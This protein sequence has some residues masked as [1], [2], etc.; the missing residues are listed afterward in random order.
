MRTVKVQIQ[1]DTAQAVTQLQGVT[2]ALLDLDAVARRAAAN[3]MA[4]LNGMNPATLLPSTVGQDAHQA[5]EAH[6]QAD[7]VKAATHKVKKTADA[8]KIVAKTDKK[9]EAQFKKFADDIGKVFGDAFEGLISGGLK[10]ALKSFQDSLKSMFVGILKQMVSN[11]ATQIKNALSKKLISAFTGGGSGGGGANKISLGNVLTPKPGDSGGGSSVALPDTGPGPHPGA[12]GHSVIDIAATQAADQIAH[13]VTGHAATPVQTTTNGTQTGAPGGNTTIHEGGNMVTGAVGGPGKFQTQIASMLPGLGLSLGGMLGMGQAGPSLLGSAGGLL[14]GG[15]G[16]AF[17]APGLLTSA[18][19]G[20]LAA[21]GTA[22]TGLGGALAGLLTNPFTIAVAGALIV[23]AIIWGINS[24]RKKEEK[25]RNQ[26]M[27]DAFSQLDD[28]LKQVNSDQLDGASA[29]TQ[30]TGIR[31][32]YVD[33]MSQLK[34]KKTRNIALKDVSRIDDKIAQIRA[35]GDQQTARKAMD[36]K[37]VPTFADGG[38]V[39]APYGYKVLGGDGAFMQ[40]FNGRVPGVYDRRDDFLARLTGNEVVLTPD[41]WMPIA[42]YLKQKRVPGFADGGMVDGSSFN[43]SCQASSNQ[44]IVIE[45]LTIHLNNQ[46]GADSAAKIL[47]VAVKTP[48]GQKAVVKSVRTHIGESGLGDGLVR[49]IN[50]VNE[51]GF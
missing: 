14:A 16:M 47:G 28:L 7:A 30:A 2:R 23:G 50:S 27:L 3:A 33:Q 43:G 51:R 13:E 38:Y 19:G 17:L 24:R 26:A 41:V 39:G 18:F 29:V 32:Q 31:K 11:I 42:P 25:Q 48:E 35:A 45:E 44:G 37:L 49:D 21:G 36:A 9:G 5:S 22:A 12:D 8:K 6:R 10:G 46:F 20:T 4:A 1:A 15:I 34:D 40:P